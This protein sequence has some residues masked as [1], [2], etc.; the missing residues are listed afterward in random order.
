MTMQKFS[1]HRPKVIYPLQWPPPENEIIQP[2]VALSHEL[3]C[4]K[5]VHLGLSKLAFVEGCPHTDVRGGLHE[6]FHCIATNHHY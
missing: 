4:T 6:G 3:M 2:W 1:C 5:R